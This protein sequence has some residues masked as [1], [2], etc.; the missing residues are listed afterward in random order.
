MPTTCWASIRCLAVP[1]D[2]IND[3]RSLVTIAGGRVLYEAPRRVPTTL[4]P[5]ESPAST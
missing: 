4:N 3:I 1:E 2:R 5:E